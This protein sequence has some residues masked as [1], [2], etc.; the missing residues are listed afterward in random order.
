MKFSINAFF[1]KCDQIRNVLR[2]W[3]HLLKKSLTENFIFCAV[4]IPSKHSSWWR[5]LEDVLKTSFV[6]VFRRRL[7][8]V[9]VKTNIFVLAICLQDVF[10]TFS[11]RLAKT[12][13]RRFENVFKTS[14]KRLQGLFKASSKRLQDIFNTFCKDI[15]QGIFKA[16]HQVS[17]F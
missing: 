8:D 16:Y 17:L 2:I 14:L 13:S 9:L 11:R 7:Q 6:F 10:K 15:F 5:R 1:I 3:S 4:Y 12:S